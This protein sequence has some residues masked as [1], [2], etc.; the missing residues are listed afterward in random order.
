MWCWLIC[1]FLGSRLLRVC[2]LTAG[3]IC[4]DLLYFA[5]CDGLL[6]WLVL[7]GLMVLL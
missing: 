4:G 3:V 2:A 6:C 7:A 5:R 1:I